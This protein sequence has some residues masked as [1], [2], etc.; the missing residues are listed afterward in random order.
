MPTLR[1]YLSFDLQ[2]FLT[3]AKVVAVEIVATIGFFYWLWHALLH[4]V[5]R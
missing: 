4:E 5:G 3:E 1:R 2:R